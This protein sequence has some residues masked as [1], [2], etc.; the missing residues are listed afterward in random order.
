M[1]RRLGLFVEADN[2]T[3]AAVQ[4]ARAADSTISYGPPELVRAGF[5]L[6]P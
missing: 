5:V 6:R 1:S 4:T 2:V 3:D